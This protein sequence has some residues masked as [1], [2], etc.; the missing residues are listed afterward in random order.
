M[1]WDE[2]AKATNL[3]PFDQVFVFS[4]DSINAAFKNIHEY[5]TVPPPAPGETPLLFGNSRI[6]KISGTLDA[7]TVSIIAPEQGGR[8]QLF[9]SLNIEKGTIRLPWRSKTLG[10]LRKFEKWKFVFQI[11]LDVRNKNYDFHDDRNAIHE[12][13]KIHAFNGGIFSMRQLYLDVSDPSRI[14][15]KFLDLDRSVLHDDIQNDPELRM[16]FR[17][18]IDTWISESTAKKENLVGYPLS[19]KPNVEVTGGPSTFV[20]TAINLQIYSKNSL[21]LGVTTN[22][23]Q[24]PYYR[25]SYPGPFADS[26]SLFCMNSKLVWERHILTVL[27]EINRETERIP[28]EPQGLP[29]PNMTFGANPSHFSS[30]DP[31]FN[32]ARETGSNG[33]LT[34]GWQGDQHTVSTSAQNLIHNVMQA[35]TITFTVQSLTRL[36]FEPGSPRIHLTGRDTGHWTMAEPGTQSEVSGRF[37]TNWSII[38][39]IQVARLGD[40]TVEIIRDNSTPLTSTTVFD[41]RKVMGRFDQNWW[42]TWFDA[43]QAKINQERLDQLEGMAA[44]FERAAQSPEHRLALPGAKVFYLEAPRFNQRGDL[45]VTISTSDTRAPENPPKNNPTQSPAAPVSHVDLSII[46]GP[47]GPDGPGEPGRPDVGNQDDEDNDPDLPPLSPI[48]SNPPQTVVIR[49][50]PA[51]R[52]HKEDRENNKGDEDYDPDLPP[53]S[54]GNSPN[55]QHPV[56]N[57]L[58]VDSKNDQEVEEDED[59]DLPPLS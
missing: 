17:D 27:H 26:G 39:L 40:G 46:T 47:E 8:L 15:S 34:W 10:W 53:L 38:L 18:L 57:D 35:S 22:H 16:Q 19:G 28:L 31:Y 45:L 36:W 7:P 56:D 48:E 12:N 5:S 44:K 24:P 41:T 49:D 2:Q 21:A 43:H 55:V 20:P 3:D 58:R 25:L 50:P 29:R 13:N 42:P 14:R 59:P 30:S 51:D 32:W 54:P 9:F 11:D 37:V 6:G 4:Q 23:A 1:S 33:A 52:D